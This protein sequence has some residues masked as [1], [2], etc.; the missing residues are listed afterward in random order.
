MA[1]YEVFIER[2]K[3]IH[4]LSAIQ[5]HLGWDQETIMPAKGAKSRSE[6]MSWLAKEQHARVIDESF[7]E[8]IEQ[9]ES[10]SSLTEDQQANVREVRRRY[11]KAV[12]LPSKF[13][14]EFALARS[15][16][17]VAWQEARAES[18]FAK[19]KPHLAKLI[20][21]TNE[22]IDYYGVETT[23]YDVLL[24]EYEFGMKVS[25][26]DPLF[27]GLKGK[28]VPLLQQIMQAKQTNPDPKLPAD[29]VFPVAAQTEFCRLVSSAT[30]FDFEAGRMDAS[31]HPFSAGLWPGDTRF[32]TRFDEQDPFSCLY[33]V[34]HETG[35]ALYEQGLDP[36]HSFTPRGDAV[37]LG[38]HESQSRF[39]ENQ[40]G[41]TPAFWKVALPWFKEHFPESPDWTPEE[42]NKIANCV[43]PGF[44]RVEADE[45]T[46]NLHIMLRYE[47]EKKIFNDNLSVEDIPNTWNQ[48]FSEWFGI[49]VPEDRLGCL[50]DIHW[51][52]A[53]FGYFP[54]YTLGNLYAAQLL[55]AME[56]D[57][58]DIDKIVESGQWQ[59]MLDWLRS[60]IHQQGSKWTPSE[61]IQNATGAPPTP[62]PFI[63]YVE[64][65]YGEL[66]NL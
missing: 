6:I 39:W 33:A 63:D 17:L 45:I 60:K 49:E 55:A 46:Y 23:R 10:D 42:L 57:I 52:M 7:C 1:S 61:L 37:S 12:K 18:D 26:Y 14:A 3:D 64:K 20:S 48:M 9:L 24:D 40:V 56:S 51:S 2:V 62:Q 13:V 27:A 16:A 19:F 36:E 32:T 53:A 4:K 21:M 38:V 66:Y 50:Q 44:I 31:T 41:R 30:G 58:G 59:P 54:T 34:M 25:D 28:L 29:M 5:G 11:D 65:K 43:E 47:L 35:H 22:K 15:Q 8:M